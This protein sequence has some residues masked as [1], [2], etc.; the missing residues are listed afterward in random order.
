[1]EAYDEPLWFSYHNFIWTRHLLFVHRI[2]KAKTPVVK[3]LSGIAAAPLSLITLICLIA[4]FMPT[5][6]LQASGM[7][8]TSSTVTPAVASEPVERVTITITSEPAGANIMVD[9][10]DELSGVTPFSIDVPKGQSF[11]VK[12]WSYDDVE[13]Y[14]LYK[15]YEQSHVADQA[16][17]VN[18]VLEQ[19]TPLEQK[20]Q[21]ADYFRLL[22]P[23]LAPTIVTQCHD[24][25]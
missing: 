10:K 5:P 21:S 6:G 14:D 19:F 4:S 7:P 11:T 24:M 2:R 23:S 3:I 8:Q 13:D 15:M 9:N 1:M 17:T 20:E 25:V 16:G 22:L 12:A 18:V